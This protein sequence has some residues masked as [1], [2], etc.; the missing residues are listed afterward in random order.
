MA[1]A[2]QSGGSK[3]SYDDSDPWGM[4][5]KLAALVVAMVATACTSSSIEQAPWMLTEEPAGRELH[6]RAEFGGSSCT[7]FHEWRVTESADTVEIEALYERSGA[8]DCTADLVFEDET[9]TL[10]Q[11][12][13]G[14]TLLGCGPDR[15]DVDCRRVTTSP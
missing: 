9:I 3:Q 4:L 7:S 12:L 11:P 10:D 6:V 1:Q 2:A 8:A 15:S 14:R 13:E 5:V